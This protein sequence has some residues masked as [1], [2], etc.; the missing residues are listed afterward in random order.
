MPQV[1]GC[2]CSSNRGR[3]VSELAIVQKKKHW[4]QLVTISFNWKQNVQLQLQ[5][6]LKV[7]VIINCDNNFFSFIFRCQLLVMSQ[8]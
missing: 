5:R 8:F 6:H 3:E 1:R 2:T 7:D 4:I